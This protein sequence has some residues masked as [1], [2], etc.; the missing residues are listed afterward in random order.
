MHAGKVI[1]EKPINSSQLEMLKRRMSYESECA[2]SSRGGLF[3]TISSA[4]PLDSAAPEDVSAVQ[5]LICHT[6]GKSESPS[7]RHTKAPYDLD[8]KA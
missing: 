4:N 8:A 7:I 6:R 1:E 2:T 5:L 3:F